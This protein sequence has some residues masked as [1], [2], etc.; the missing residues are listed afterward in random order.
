MSQPKTHADYSNSELKKGLLT[1]TL[2]AVL[3]NHEA[4]LRLAF[5]EI[6]AFG[7]SG[8]IISVPEIIQTY[9]SHLGV[10]DKY[11]ETLTIAAVKVVYH[12]L[13]KVPGSNFDHFIAQT[14]KLLTSFK[15]LIHTHYSQGV[16]SSVKAKSLYVKPDLI[17]FDL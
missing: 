17:P 2:P 9:V 16:Y 1:G 12:F 8:A 14:P 4:H 5:N 6:N 7:I 11:N 3:F 10:K 15:E 13:L